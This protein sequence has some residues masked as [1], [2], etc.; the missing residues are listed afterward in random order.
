MV[1]IAGI[2]AVV[3]DSLVLDEFLNYA[4]AF[5]STLK[6]RRLVLGRDTRLSGPMLDHLVKA[7]AIA[8]GV[9]VLDLG[10]VPT[11]TVG[12]MVRELRAGGGI[13][14]TA[15]HN[16]PE[17]NALKFFSRKGSFL[18]PKEFEA[19][20]KVFADRRFHRAS[21]E[22]LGSAQTVY[23]PIAV[24]LDRVLDALPVAAIRRRKFRVVLDACNG[25]GLS[26]AEE[27]FR[28][29]GVTVGAIHV[30]QTRK[31][32]RPAEPLA[33][34]LGKLKKAVVKFKADVGFALDPDADRLAIVDENGKAIGEERTLVLAADFVLRDEPTPL[35]CNLSTTRA[36]DDVAARYGVKVHRTPIGEA[37]VV[38]KMLAVRSGIGGEGNGGVI[39]PRVHLGR[40]SATGM[41][42]VLARL[43]VKDGGAYRT[44]SEL[45]ATIPDYVMIKD[46]ID[47]P[48]LADARR[49]LARIKQA[50]KTVDH[51]PSQPAPDIDV[52]DGLKISFSDHWLHVRPSGTE[53][54]MRI[55]A[56]APNRKAARALIDWARAA[57]K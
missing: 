55:F 14:L 18:T 44:L 10:V 4:Q 16:P 54:I 35:V 3:G 20:K 49:G 31:F 6:P 50:L 41:G 48:T 1:S 32:E 15:S 21:V 25:A 9:D 30:D 53:P 26:L 11:P 36:I 57:L 24:H 45:N 7:A 17:W 13:A 47:L 39:Y 12:L 43:A 46:K 52:R 38:Q 37:H 29:L 23:D 34:N 40:D 51:D 27:L 56:E 19:L 33:R 42:L 28:R 22:R 8:A 2:R 5:V